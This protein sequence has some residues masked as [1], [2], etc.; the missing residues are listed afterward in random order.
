MGHFWAYVLYYLYFSQSLSL[1][2]EIYAK[3]PVN[4]LE[5]LQWNNEEKRDNI[6]VII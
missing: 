5:G 3:T 4:F 2:N 1:R 6:V